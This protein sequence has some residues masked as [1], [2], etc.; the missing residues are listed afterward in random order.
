MKFL[1]M[2]HTWQGSGV[3]DVSIDKKLFELACCFK[4][5]V[6]GHPPCK[7]EIK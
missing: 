7:V 5:L 2:H 1:I 3:E 6:G 4:L